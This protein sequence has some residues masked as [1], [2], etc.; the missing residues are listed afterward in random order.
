[1]KTV[2]IR[3]RPEGTTDDTGQVVWHEPVP[4]PRLGE[5]VVLSIDNRYAMTIDVVDIHHHW[6]VDTSPFVRI[7]Y[8]EVA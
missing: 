3:F 5:K 4:L 2:S 8:K 7:T 6:Y 1:M